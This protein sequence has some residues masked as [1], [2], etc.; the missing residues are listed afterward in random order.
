MNEQSSDI[1]Q[2][3]A[4][5]KIADIDKDSFLPQYSVP[6]NSL[7]VYTKPHCVYNNIDRIFAVFALVLGFFVI[8]VLMHGGNAFGLA[9]TVTMCLITLFN[10]F[11]SKK[12]GLNLTVGH[13]AVYGLTFL[14]SLMFVITDNDSV[15]NIDFCL[16]IVSNLYL[17][18]S[19]YK[20]N[21]RSIIF[22]ACK[23]V[24]VSPF[25]EYSSVFGALFHKDTSQ[26]GGD[27][28]KSNLMPVI[29]G[30]VCSVPV[31]L[32]VAMLLLS[33][34]EMFRSWYSKLGEAFFDDLFLNLFIFGCS[35]PIGMYIFGA[36]YS[37]AY[38][39]SNE[40][41]L[42]KLPKAS[43]RVCPASMCNAFL[44][45]LCILYVIYIFCQI[46]YFFQT[47]GTIVEDTFDYSS[48]A[49]Q[50]FFEL[51]VVAVINLILAACVMF[52]VKYNEKKLPVTVK[53]FIS[54]FSVLTLCLIATAL[55]KM[56]MYIKIYGLT[57]LRVYTS[58][59]MIYLFVLFVILI[60]KQACSKISF[61][62]IAYF[63]AAAVIILM[64]VIPVDGLI[65]KYNLQ[66]YTEG[67]ID[68]IGTS[69]LKQLDCSA[70]KYLEP[71]SVLNGDDYDTGRIAVSDYLNNTIR[72]LQDFDIYSFNFTKYSAYLSLKKEEPDNYIVFG[73]KKYHENTSYETL[74]VTWSDR[75]YVPF[76]D[77][78]LSQVGDCLG[79]YEENGKKFYVCELNGQSTEEWLTVVSD[80]D[81]LSDGTIYGNIGNIDIP[82]EL[83]E[84]YMYKMGTDSRFE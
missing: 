40:K 69:A 74:A 71:Y 36:V 61:T 2:N 79:Y 3:I 54:G 8:K 4:E 64:S 9:A 53:G 35:L 13:T 82:D 28:K 10:F 18:Y 19:S 72:D 73:T 75:E 84:Y 81:G 51:C 11:Y 66:Q 57:P 6:E 65:A 45:P 38:K 24:F 59:F 47:V 70:V 20:S 52:F 44:T 42:R 63:M 21:N 56:I 26:G 30:L 78:E 32:F 34:D 55:T 39:K 43:I 60:I 83:S 80:L 15:K 16:V 1:S 14:L 12:S 22:N 46:S 49:R 76:C 50:G 48:Y 7:W 29:V 5:N 68:W 23:S 27:K 41:F 58:I 33:S 25:Y 77:A 62:K 37:R 17:V 67:K 31:T